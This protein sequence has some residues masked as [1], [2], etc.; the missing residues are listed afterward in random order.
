MIPATRVQLRNAIDHLRRHNLRWRIISL[1]LW[2][3]QTGTLSGI[4]CLGTLG[5]AEVTEKLGTRWSMALRPIAAEDLREQ[6]YR[7]L[8]RVWTGRWWG[9]GTSL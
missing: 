4:A 1:H 7:T 8:R 2:L 5:P 9:G 3:T 6:V